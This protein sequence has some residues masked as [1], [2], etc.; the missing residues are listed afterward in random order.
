MWLRKT[1]M[2]QTAARA[3]RG[4]PLDQDTVKVMP[5]QLKE[6]VDRRRATS[7]AS[8]ARPPAS[9]AAEHETPRTAKRRGDREAE[10]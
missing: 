1:V 7:R 3:R 6:A 10:R 5:A 2:G 8:R 4:R 9:R